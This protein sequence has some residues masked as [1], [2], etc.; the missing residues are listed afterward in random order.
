MR[1][2][3]FVFVIP[4]AFLAACSGIKRC[5]YESP[6][7]DQWQ[8]PEAVIAALALEPGDRVA[9]LG[10]GS[11]Y[12]TFRL[13]DAV[14]PEGRVYAVDVDEDMLAL[15]RER[16]AEEGASQVEVVHASYDD[17][18][19]PEPGVDVILTVDTY[20]HLEDREA[21]F[22][23]LAESLKPGGRLAVIDFDEPAGFIH[24]TFLS[25]HRMDPEV[26]EAELSAAGYRLQERHDFL[27]QQSFMV[28]AAADEAAQDEASVRPG[29]NAPFLAEDL[30]VEEWTN[31]FEV[32]SREIYLQREAITDALEIEPGMGVADIGSGT[33]LFLSLL[34]DRVGSEGTVYATDIAPK[35]VAHLKDR[36]AK[37]DLDQV[38][39]VRGGEREVGLPAASVD[40]AFVCDVYH[41][42]EF[43][44]ASLASLMEAIRP[45]GHLVVI[46]FER[47]P[48]ETPEWIVNHVRAGKDVFRSEIEGAGFTLVEEVDVPGMKENYFLR[49]KRP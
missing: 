40:V 3:S 9:D 33:G 8:Q 25:S 32:E 36:V 24:R 21:Y 42:F 18:R 34:N 45:G 35:F 15:L 4:V 29:I 46:D 38:E 16:V 43:P 31:R 37:E 5:S 27:P 7:R 20:H 22:A 6:G 14:G 44:K 47:I 10:A 39:V 11:G 12:F 17:A 1:F 2:K 30:D 28:F 26:I 41:H 13:A 48:G 49:F 19:I 23:R